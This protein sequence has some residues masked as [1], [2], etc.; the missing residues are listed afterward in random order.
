LNDSRIGSTAVRILAGIVILFLVA[1]AGIVIWRMP[2]ILRS[3]RMASWISDSKAQRVHAP[4]A[5]VEA[6]SPGLANGDP[7]DAK[8]LHSWVEVTVEEDALEQGQKLK[9]EFHD[10]GAE[11]SAGYEAVHLHAPDYRAPLGSGSVSLAVLGAAN[12]SLETIPSRK[13]LNPRGDAVDPAIEKLFDLASQQ[14]SQRDKIGLDLTVVII[15]GSLGRSRWRAR[16]FYDRDTHMAPSSWYSWND[17]SSGIYMSTVLPVFHDAALSAV[18]SVAFGEPVLRTM[19]WQ[20][21]EIQGS[22]DFPPTVRVLFVG[23]GAGVVSSYGSG[24][25]LK[26]S[27]E[28]SIRSLTRQNQPADHFALIAV[29]PDALAQQV[30]IT[31]VSTSGKRVK[32]SS[33]F[34]QL[35]DAVGF[36]LAK[37]E[38]AH[39]EVAYLPR[40]ARILLDLPDAGL[41]APENVGITNL[42]QCRIP[43]ARFE[44]D[45][46]LIETI[47]QLTQLRI[48]RSVSA[49]LPPEQL[50]RH[51]PMK[52]ENSTPAEMLER[53]RDLFPQC[54]IRIDSAKHAILID[55]RI[56]FEF[57]QWLRGKLPKGWLGP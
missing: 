33:Q 3:M 51:F 38:I 22:R 53:Y 32:G 23:R 37:E 27:A 52:L 39:L 18:A 46:E 28:I 48:Y 7:W 11:F 47:G 17:K 31:A 29:E 35:P 12:V 25:G 49:D 26:K 50:A 13:Y 6:S 4:T 1:A 2:E 10:P 36:A 15:G 55:E 56:P 43:V 44:N 19:S 40:V 24:S 14:N 21:G 8:F 45:E 20:V 9:V 30:E 54:E 57:V 5:L 34:G 42:F 41:V 16:G